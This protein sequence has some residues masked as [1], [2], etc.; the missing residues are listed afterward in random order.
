[1][2]KDAESG[3]KKTSPKIFLNIMNDA[4]FH[5]VFNRI[6][7]RSALFRHSEK[8]SLP[9]DKFYLCV[10]RFCFQPQCDKK[11]KNIHT[12]SLHLFHISF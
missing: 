9:C 1:M 6:M 11:H 7:P 8:K 5:A 12:F 2:E 10:L 3:C 4:G